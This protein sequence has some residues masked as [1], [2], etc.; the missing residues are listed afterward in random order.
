M[1]KGPGTVILIRAVGIGAQEVHVS[2]LDRVPPAD[3]ADDA[4]H[5][6]RLAAAVDRVAGIVEVDAVKRRGEAVGIAFA[7]HLAVGDDVESGALLV[8][9]RDQGGVVL[10]LLQ[11]FRRDPPELA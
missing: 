2:D 8:A 9:D 6:V 10:R 1:V 3:L 11:P 5:G 7:P 4:R